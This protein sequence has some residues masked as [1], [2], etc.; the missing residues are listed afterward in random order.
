MATPTLPA[1]SIKS[2][3]AIPNVAGITDDII[4]TFTGSEALAVPAV[5]I[6]GEPADYVTTEDSITWTAIKKLKSTDPTGAIPFTI[7]FQNQSAEAGVQV[8]ATTDASSVTFGTE[9]QTLPKYADIGRVYQDI[10]KTIGANNN[11]DNL[12]T[13]ANEDASSQ[14]QAIFLNN[15]DTDDLAAVPWFTD[16]A[17]ELTTAVFWKKSNGTDEQKQMAK[18]IIADAHRILVERFFPQEYI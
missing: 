10:G 17:T 14:L 4:L 5:T 15:V 12:V 3:N 8:T 18:D 9:T 2:N 1:V 13:R 16:L 6:A 7:D 11:R